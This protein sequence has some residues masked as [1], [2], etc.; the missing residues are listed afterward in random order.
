M[1][2]NPADDTLEV[3][4]LG[5]VRAIRYLL[6]DALKDFKA[7]VAIGQKLRDHEISREEFSAAMDHRFP[8]PEGA[9]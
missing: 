6:N 9:P 1:P 8:P 3:K 2:T 4:P 5:F 7:A